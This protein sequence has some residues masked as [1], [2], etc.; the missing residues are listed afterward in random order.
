M[1]GSCLGLPPALGCPQ[2]EMASHA[3][4]GRSL[5]CGKVFPR[6]LRT[7]VVYLEN[8]TWCKYSRG[9]F[10]QGHGRRKG[11]FIQQTPPGAPSLP[12]ECN[13]PSSTPTSLDESPNCFSVCYHLHTG[14]RRPGF[15]SPLEALVHPGPRH[16]SAISFIQGEYTLFWREMMMS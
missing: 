12:R 13:P 2:E 9:K 8:G 15:L 6:C 7:P 10:S 5:L 14:W 16:T 4:P 11:P 3:S 1:G